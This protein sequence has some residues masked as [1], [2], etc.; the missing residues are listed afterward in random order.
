MLSR[1]KESSVL[2]KYA[3]VFNLL[4]LGTTL[5]CFL[6]ISDWSEFVTSSVDQTMTTNDEL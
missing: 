2:D 4:V 5:D 6:E 1:K 3:G